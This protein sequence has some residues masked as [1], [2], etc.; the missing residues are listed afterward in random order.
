M[1]AARRGWRAAGL[2]RW[3]PT[4]HPSC[5][6]VLAVQRGAG[7]DDA[8]GVHQCVD[9][10]EA[11]HR[12]RHPGLGASRARWPR[13][14]HSSA[15][16]GART[17]LLTRQPRSRRCAATAAADA[18]AGTADH[19]HAPLRIKHRPGPPSPHGSAPHDPAPLR[20]AAAAPRNRRALRAARREAAA[21]R[22]RGE[23]R[24]LAADRGQ[25]PAAVLGARHRGEQRQRVRVQRVAED[26]SRD[27]RSTTRPAYITTTRRRSRRRR[28]GCA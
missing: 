17:P 28:P 1:R 27:P 21:R 3:W 15:A 2:S 10:P 13:S 4:S 24:H 8:G 6:L 12:G 23:R 16:S 20:R 26:L 7:R 25:P 11:R 22:H 14:E 19:H 9:P 5:Q 18:A